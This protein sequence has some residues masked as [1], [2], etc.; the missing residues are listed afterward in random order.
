MI[1]IFERNQSVCLNF[2]GEIV[3]F[4]GKCHMCQVIL[5]LVVSG[6]IKVDSQNKT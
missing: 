5:K 3:C 1:D 6:Y 2:R 4:Q